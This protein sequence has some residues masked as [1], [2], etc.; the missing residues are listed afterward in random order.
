LA[1]PDGRR[2]GA[3]WLGGLFGLLWL[4]GGAAGAQISPGPLS[5]AH[6]SLEGATQ[7]TACHKL[8][9]GQTQLKCLEC[10]SEI[11]SRLAGRRGLHPTYVNK[12]G[13]EDCAR[14]HSEHN[15][16]DFSTVHWDPRPG[17]FDH[18]KTGYK[19]EGK[20][21][22]LTCNQCHNRE[23]IPA[24]ERAGIRMKD[25]NRTF[26]GLS[27]QCSTC[28]QD[29]HKGQLG[30][31][32]QQCHTAE[33]WKK[34]S[35]TFDHSKT[36]YPLT[37]AHA[38]VKCEKCHTP[39][40]DG[41]PRY[42]GLVFDR[43]TACH[44]DPH[45]G[46]FPQT[47]QTCHNTGGWKRISPA[48]L[49]GNF[50]HAKTKFPLLGKHLDVGCGKCHAS[51][52]FKKPLVFQKCAN[53]HQPDPHRGQ[54]AKRPE[55]AECAGCHTVEGWKPAKFGVPEHAKT[56]YPLEGKHA[57]VECAKCHIP[58]GTATLFK[59][60]FA[61][62]VD[63]HADEHVGQFAAAP[64]R[65]RCENCHAVQ[66][67]RPSS[68]TLAKHQETRFLLTGG[69]RAVPCADCHKESATAAPKPVKQYRF[70]ERNCTVCH[71]DPHQGQFQ[72]RM[73]K[74]RADGTAAGCEA[75]HSTGSWKDLSR[76]DHAA[77]AFPLQGTHRATACSGC[78]KPPN[79]EVKLMHVDFRAAP[80][81]CEECH[82][83]IHGGQFASAR[84]ATSC[85]DC[86]NSAKW[87]PSLFDHDTRTAFAL[88]G[89]HRN[90]RCDACHKTF[91]TIESRKVLWYKPTP[92][93]C[94][95]CHGPAEQKTR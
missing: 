47:C 36:R 12:P 56:G 13:S 68:F 73:R 53:C 95:A 72:E 34:V 35:E 77:T 20:H 91:Q 46:A 80:K 11:A 3:G 66:T 25:L 71:A 62:C 85:G 8:G 59:V 93:E 22:G 84:K 51:G 55:G 26:L 54:F 29:F 16:A 40:D 65:N 70:E 39:G 27:Q 9:A 78:H 90:V 49:S 57:T 74:V 87:K 82:E 50:D 79:F 81:Q 14:C 69:H 5:K 1:N 7:C 64:Y 92:K 17:V 75:C 37:G 67:Y 76:F 33:D 42:Q 2:Y 45:K 52:D 41:K 83:D 31:N 6:S 44:A 38:Q 10:H 18:S 21:A 28:H 24:G 94:A 86:H 19:L 60:K 61:Q 88:Q 30:P 43:C 48:V 63:C 15:G 32:C 89:V 4:L 23:R 58:K